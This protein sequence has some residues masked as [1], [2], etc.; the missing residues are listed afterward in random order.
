MMINVEDGD[1]YH[2]LIMDDQASTDSL[3]AAEDFHPV[4]IN[5]GEVHSSSSE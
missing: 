4:Q 3:D 1:D 2:R 5:L